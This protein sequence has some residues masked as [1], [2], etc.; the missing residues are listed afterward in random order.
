MCRPVFSFSKKLR[1][2]LLPADTNMQVLSRRLFLRPGMPCGYAV[3]PFWGVPGSAD[4]H[5]PYVTGLFYGPVGR[6]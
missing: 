3:N 1:F 2:F 4:L 5:E 6:Q